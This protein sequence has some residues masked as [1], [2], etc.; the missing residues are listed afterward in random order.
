MTSNQRLMNKLFYL[1]PMIFGWMISLTGVAGLL[2][3]A[4][5]GR[6][7]DAEVVP[8]LIPF[9]MLPAML[10]VAIPLMVLVYK[11][12]AALPASHSR[13]T[14]GLAVGLLFIP[15]FNL[16]WMFQAF[17]GWTQDF[18]RYIAASGSNVKQAPQGLAMTIC[19]FTLLS[20]I[21]LLGIVFALLNQIL[22]LVFVSKAINSVNSFVASGGKN[23]V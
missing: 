4:A 23:S 15:I 11:L 12:W 9:A 3:I 19:I 7:R 17:W 16:Y 13:T 1:L 8:L 10:G 22:L 20:M 2:F 21:P 18:N 5:Q 14:P 6:G